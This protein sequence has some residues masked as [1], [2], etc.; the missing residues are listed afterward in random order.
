MSE[1]AVRRIAQTRRRR[2]ERLVARA[3]DE[4]PPDV[5][6]QLENV[7][8]VIEDEPA[9]RQ[10]ARADDADAL[11]GLYEGIPLTERD[12]AY[13]MVLPDK[14]TIF[15]GPL[16]RSFRSPSAI[17]REVRITVAHELGHHLGLDEDRLE[18]IG[19]G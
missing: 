17:A 1:A 3:I 5:L 12:S 13:G 2:F 6:A 14:I 11:F 4:L 18:D 7:E 8:I 10:M 19:L 16:E 15:R 9:P